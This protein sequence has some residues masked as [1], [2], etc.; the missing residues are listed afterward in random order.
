MALFRFQT[1]ST[2]RDR[3][4]DEQRVERIRHVLNEVLHEIEH[5][6]TGFSQR[7]DSVASDV[8][9][10]ME[11]M[12]NEGDDANSSLEVEEKTRALKSFTQRIAVLERQLDTLRKV[13][14]EIATMPLTSGSSTTKG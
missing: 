13:D 11:S 8:A 10:F 5:E 14:S 3:Q 2:E 12:E 1:R 4:S 7:Y 6:K 9:F